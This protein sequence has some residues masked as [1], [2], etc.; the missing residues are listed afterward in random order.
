MLKDA[1][2][3]VR[4]I[5]GEFHKKT[6]TTSAFFHSL[7]AEQL[8]QV[9]HSYFHRGREAPDIEVDIA[10]VAL[11]CLAYLNWLGKDASEAFAKSLEKHKRV[12]EAL[13]R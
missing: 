5:S 11:C 6:V 2:E 9:A 13:K 4:Q 3:A 10:D 8:G 7:L 12:V 1:Q